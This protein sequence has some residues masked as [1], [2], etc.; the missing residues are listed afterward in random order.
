M[1]HQ[2]FRGAGQAGIVS[3]GHADERA[4]RLARCGELDAPAATVRE[5][6]RELGA[7]FSGHGVPAMSRTERMKAWS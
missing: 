1:A 7:E 2:T 6:L 4:A 5:S 3:T